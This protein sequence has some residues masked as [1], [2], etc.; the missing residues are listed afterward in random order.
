[1]R[2]AFP[3]HFHIE[4]QAEAPLTHLRGGRRHGL[5]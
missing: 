2:T 4:G 5:E 3:V 1:L